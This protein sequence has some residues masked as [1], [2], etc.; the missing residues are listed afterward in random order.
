MATTLPNFS[1]LTPSY[2][3]DYTSGKDAKAAFLAGKDFTLAATGQQTSIADV[4]PGGTVLL[5]FKR[6][7]GVV[8]LKVTKA[9]IEAVGR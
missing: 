7:T 6:N 5:R 3:R 2:G 8:S 1:E 9:Q 4:A